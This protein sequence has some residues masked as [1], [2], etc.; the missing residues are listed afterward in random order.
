MTPQ[1]EKRDARDQKR[2]DK[3][4]L[5]RDTP[6]PHGWMVMLFTPRGWPVPM[7]NANSDDYPVLF[8]TEEDAEFAAGR[9]MWGRHFGY[10]VFEWP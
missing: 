7:S 10:Q 4:I 5:R 1:E 8:R 9:N 3:S 2:V 6:N